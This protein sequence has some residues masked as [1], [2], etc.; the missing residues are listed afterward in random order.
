MYFLGRFEELRQFLANSCINI[1]PEKEFFYYIQ[2]LCYY[3][4]ITEKIIDT[5]NVKTYC[6]E[7]LMAINNYM[8]KL[9]GFVEEVNKTKILNIKYVK[10][11]IYLSYA[12]NADKKL[13]L[14]SIDLLKGV[15]DDFRNAKIEDD[16][17]IVFD[18]ENLEYQEAVINFLVEKYD[19]ASEQFEEILKKK[20]FKNDDLK[21]SDVNFYLALSLTYLLRSKSDKEQNDL[22]SLNTR[23]DIVQ[24]LKFVKKESRFYEKSKFY[25]AYNLFKIGEFE[26]A[27]GYL[28]SFEKACSNNDTGEL[29]E[30][31]D[32]Y[33]IKIPFYL[34]D[35]HMK[36]GDRLEAVD[37]FRMTSIKSDIF[38]MNN[39]DFI[40]TYL[41]S[42]I[43][44]IEDFHQLSKFHKTFYRILYFKAWSL[45]YLKSYPELESFIKEY[46]QFS[47]NLNDLNFLKPFASFKINIVKD[48]PE[49]MIEI[50]NQF[51]QY[52]GNDNTNIIVINKHDTDRREKDLVAI[53]CL[54]E[55]YKKTL[56]KLIF[57]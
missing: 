12:D 19:K 51:E 37:K 9:K 48:E 4:L 5:E 35:Q 25:L 2:S 14:N 46:D 49:A 47:I 30:K 39:K 7:G 52:L 36:T 26:Q 40:Q 34:A 53:F 55:I 31:F 3:K 28:E 38:L 24:Y 1:F 17:L 27:L 41:R 11:V 6:D 13:Y 44:K 50:S 21:L 43:S 8:S 22:A 16:D 10:T 15:K 32:E 29:K 33:A 20:Y 45:F 23:K 18:L 54:S 57:I 42:D 56:N